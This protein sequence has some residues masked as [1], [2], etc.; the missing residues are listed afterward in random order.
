MVVSSFL[1]LLFIFI[2][3]QSTV[4]IEATSNQ[5]IV[6][7]ESGSLLVME[8]ESVSIPEPWKVEN[9][10]SDFTG[11]SYIRFDGNT[12]QLGPVNGVISYPFRILNSGTY[13]LSLRSNKN[14]ADTTWSNDCYMRLLNA[15][16]SLFDGQDFTKLFMSGP[17]N[18]WSYHT[19]LEFDDGSKP[20]P[21]FALPAG[22]YTLQ[23]GGRSKNYFI[24]RIILFD[25][26]ILTK[27]CAEDTSQPESYY[28]GT[29][30]VSAPP[31]I[32]ASPSVS[33]SP[34]A[35]CGFFDWILALLVKIGTLG[36]VRLCDH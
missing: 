20:V 28:D 1:A 26:T 16:D 8:A 18:Q 13:R 34:S 24:D 31:S 3:A 35:N 33:C 5:P 23:I 4:S 32:S 19:Q 15:D 14:N 6:F 30:S 22:Q 11:D 21:F 27:A 36:L 29:P 12:V 10:V 7:E 9:M 25:E 17:A 2:E